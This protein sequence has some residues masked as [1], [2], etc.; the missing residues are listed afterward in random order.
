MNLN[1]WDGAPDWYS[2][3]YGDLQ[4][5]RT[6]Y[7]DVGYTPFFSNVEGKRTTGGIYDLSKA[8]TSTP[9]T[10]LSAPTTTTRPST[11]ITTTTQGSI[12]PTKLPSTTLLA[13]TPKTTYTGQTR[14]ITTEQIKAGI[15]ASRGTGE[16]LT[17]VARVSQPVIIATSGGGG[18]GGP[19]EE[20][21]QTQ[22]ETTTEPTKGISKNKAIIAVL[23][24]VGL[25]WYFSS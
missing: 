15:T 16:T 2:L 25:I 4:N 21:L 23:A 10:T 11:S 18:G 14:G 20:A 17:N 5:Y 22:A 9:T 24:G 8:V 12:T 6:S 19:Q 1:D 3:M 7:R 13:T